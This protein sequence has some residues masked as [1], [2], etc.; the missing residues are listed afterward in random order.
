MKSVVATY[1]CALSFVLLLPFCGGVDRP[2][3]QDLSSDEV[4]YQTEDGVRIVAGWFL[5]EGV[6]T[7]PVVILL[8]ERDGTRAQWDGPGVPGILVENGYAV[9][10]P[11]LR[12]H[13][14]SNVV[15]RD[16]REEPYEFTN[17]LDAMLDVK[18]AIEWLKGRSDVDVSR[19][20]VIGARMGGDM[21]YAST[22]A[23]PEVK[24]GIVISPD[25]YDPKS[26][27]P[28]YAA[29]PDF[30]PHDI[31]Y[32]AGSRQA[33]EAASSIGVRT[34][35]IGGDRYED[36]SDLDG[37]ALLTIDQPIK[38]ILKWFETRLIA[39]PAPRG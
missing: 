35:H 1:F 33:W 34:D 36:H 12:G 17:S 27:D 20:A 11:D 13:G 37:V 26:L 8:H 31:F 14:E 39:T 15:I 22:A 10:A 2:S 9:L 23:F 5:P 21:A 24:T 16:G 3:T 32:M 29:I 25:P 4:T 30:A 6:T 19:I 28:L 7:P 38:D 18:A